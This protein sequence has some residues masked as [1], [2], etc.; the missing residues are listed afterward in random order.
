MREIWRCSAS[1]SVR[2]VAVRREAAKPAEP[3]EGSSVAVAGLHCCAR[4]DLPDL[5]WICCTG[6][7]QLSGCMGCVSPANLVCP[8][9]Q[10]PSVAVELAWS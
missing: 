3:S 5:L 10:H 8:V 4:P 2:L 7:G 9:V 1:N 6:Q